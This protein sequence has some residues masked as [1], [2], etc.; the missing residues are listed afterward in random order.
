MGLAQL[1]GDGMEMRGWCCPITQSRLYDVPHLEIRSWLLRCW[2]PGWLY[3]LLLK[4]CMNVKFRGGE[5]R[6]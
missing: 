1:L 4:L 5:R 2:L 6:M 3:Y